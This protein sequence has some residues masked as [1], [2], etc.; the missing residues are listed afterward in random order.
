M[1]PPAFSVLAWVKAKMS[2]SWA[3]SQEYP[4]E[5]N[6]KISEHAASL[7]VTTPSAKQHIFRCVSNESH[8]SLASIALTKN[9]ICE[10]HISDMNTWGFLLF[11]TVSNGAAKSVFMGQRLTGLGTK[12]LGTCQLSAF[13]TFSIFHYPKCKHKCCCTEVMPPLR[14]DGPIS[15]YAEPWKYL[16]TQSGFGNVTIEKAH[17]TTNFPGQHFC[18]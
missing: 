16:S 12:S 18:P 10:W 7:T 15:I 6:W 8:L 9:F 1:L 3:F 4:L 11:F 14:H 17:K 13:S 5:R 2:F